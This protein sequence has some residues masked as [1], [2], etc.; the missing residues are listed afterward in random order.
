MPVEGCLDFE[1]RGRWGLSCNCFA[2]KNQKCN[3]ATVPKNDNGA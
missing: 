2:F 1:S 3:E